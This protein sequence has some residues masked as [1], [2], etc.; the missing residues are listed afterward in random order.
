M[1]RTVRIIA[2]IIL[3]LGYGVTAFGGG[4]YL[5]YNA[6]SSGSNKEVSYNCASAHSPTRNQVLAARV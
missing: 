3:L 1:K 5:G 2:S 6:A 4:I